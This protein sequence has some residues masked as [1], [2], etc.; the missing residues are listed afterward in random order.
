MYF[1][2]CSL[3]SVDKFLFFVVV[4]VFYLVLFRVFSSAR[5]I[6]TLKYHYF[7]F[8]NFHILR[9]MHVITRTR[10]YVRQT[11]KTQNQMNVERRATKKKEGKQQWCVNKHTYCLLIEPLSAHKRTLSV[12]FINICLS[13]WFFLFGMVC[14]L[15]ILE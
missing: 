11:K 1:W 9:F 6:L 15:S 14:L 12:S 13:L 2:H 8:A 3:S 7:P 5:G 10:S 4:I